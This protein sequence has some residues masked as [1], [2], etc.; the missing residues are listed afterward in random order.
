[1]F[2]KRK[3]SVKTSDGIKIKFC[4]LGKWMRKKDAGTSNISPERLLKNKSQETN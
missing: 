3:R 2:S 1:M 4:E